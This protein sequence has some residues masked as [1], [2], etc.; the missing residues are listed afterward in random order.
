LSDEV[1][2]ED[3]ERASRKMVLAIKEDGNI[4]IA[5]NGG[6]ASDAQH[7]AAELVGRYMINRP[8][9]S[10]IA[11]NTDTSALTAISND[12]GYEYIFARQI[13]AIGKEGDIFLAI[14]TSGNSKNIVLALEE[15]KRKGI[16]T[17]LLTGESGG[18]GANICDLAIRVP[19]EKT[20]RIQEAHI[21]IGHILCDLIEKDIYG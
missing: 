2:L 19:S 15:A 21:L 7:I 20:P 9:I 5:G 17:I 13:A 14:S 11:L 18:I 1:L 10:A 12:F 16:Y 3:I 8:P 6:S 4:L